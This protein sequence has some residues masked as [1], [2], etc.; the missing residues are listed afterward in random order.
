[1]FRETPKGSRFS[2]FFV[3][4]VGISAM[5]QAATTSWPRLADY[6][7]LLRLAVPIVVV[8]VGVMLMGAVDTLM[9]GHVSPA[10]L[11]AV[12]LG[13]L[14]SIGWLMFGLGVLFA[15]DP[16]VSQ[17]FGAGDDVAVGRAVQRGFFIALVVTL[18]TS[19]L[20]LAVDPVLTWVGQ[21]AAVVPL[22]AGYV[23]RTV[24]SVF[25]FL[26]FVVLRQ[27]LQAQART[28]PIVVTIFVA[29]AVNAGLNYAWIFGHFGFPELGVLG[30][31]WATL[32]SRWFMALLLLVL[33]W[34]HLRPYI[35]R[36]VSRVLSPA[37]FLRMLALGAPI[38]GQMLLE[39][40][41][42]ATIALLMGWLGI[43]Q[44]AA[45]QIA[46][47]LASLT[48][49][50]PLGIASAATVR[51]GH[52][53]GRGDP[54]ALRQAAASAL[55]IGAGFMAL[56]GIAFFA[57]PTFFAAWYTDDMEVL[58]IAAAL[59]PIAGIFQIFDGTQV[60]SLGVLRGLGDTRV[61]VAVALVGFWC[62]GIPTSVWLGFRAGLGAT[63][64]WWGFVV[65]LGIVAAIL[66]MRVQHMTLRPQAR[67][68]ID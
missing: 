67:L 41:A 68:E 27:S 13:N 48:F 39:W 64:L 34:P 49:M 1:L 5:N 17:A 14:Y 29:N 32:V 18:P 56:T 19:L 40:G 45:H 50:V 8:Q 2:G 44:V 60:V 30:S 11:A 53:V 51:V 43:A 52:A 9:V 33:G 36:R 42:F 59:I 20:L 37:P 55:C 38:G 61:P 58:Q 3:F 22:A 23:Y 21:P 4:C 47:T 54:T 6:R 46:L 31:A 16:L 62:L 25:P 12:A 7:D 28:A 24:G 15:L 10:A 26:A 65:G 57:A 66:F 35:A 63:G